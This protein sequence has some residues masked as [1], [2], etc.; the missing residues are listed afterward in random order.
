MRDMRGSRVLFALALIGVVIV[1]VLVLVNSRSEDSDDAADTTVSTAEQ[2][3]TSTSTS[4]TTSSTT[5]STP[6]PE[7]SDDEAASIVWPSPGAEPSYDEPL[8]VARGF[9]EDV[10]GFVDPRYGDFQQGDSRSGEV[11]V[12][13]AAGGPTTTVLVRQMSDDRWYV[14]GAVSSELELAE[15]TA[16]SAIDHPLQVMGRA[17]AFEGQVRVAVYGRGDAAALGEG[18][19]TGSGTEDLGPFSGEIGWDNPGGGWGSVILTTAGGADGTTWAALAIPV[20]F[21]GGD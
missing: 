6:P 15:P 4:S 1:V 2:T 9:A 8:A 16:G 10:A 20:G 21:I 5:T 3:S 17:R 13:H 18:F 14:I 7:V 19:V 11:E 12:Q